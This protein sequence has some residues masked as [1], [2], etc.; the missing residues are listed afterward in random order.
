MMTKKCLILILAIFMILGT[1]LP[2]FAQGGREADPEKEIE[3][4]WAAIW[5][6]MD[7]KAQPIAALV[8][9]FNV[10]NAG[11]I[12]VVI[13]PQPDYN[14]Y[15]TKVRTSLAAGIAPADI[16]TIRVNPTTEEF[17]KSKLVMDFTDKLIGEWKKQFDP[18]TLVQSTVDGKL[19]S[20]PYEIAILP[21]W[22]NMQ[23]LKKVGINEIPKTED[24]FWS[25]MNK[26]K[27]AG[28]YPSS[29]MTGDNNAWTSMIWFSHFAISL[30]GPDVWLKPFTDPIFV[31]AA[32]LTKRMIVE[33]STPDAIGL[34]AGDSGGHFLA[35]RTA[36]FTNGPWY[37]GREDLKA[38]P[39][40]NDIVV[41]GLPAFGQYSN[42]MVSRI[43]G[44]LMAAATKD[45]AR[46]QAIIKFLKF[47]TEPTNVKKIAE[48]SGAMFAIAND[49]KPATKLQ[50]GF[51]QLARDVSITAL[52]VATAI[53]AE[54]TLEFTQQLSN[55]ALGRID[56]QEFTRRVYAKII[57]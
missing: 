15:D 41:A 3:L 45:P 32:E 25:V 4:R 11:K 21:I 44:N 34:R 35:Q 38:T 47:M 9:E 57:D 29:Q 40:Y 5:V 54:A 1:M 36:V 55:L 20:I 14:A 49:A 52:D 10:S 37:G 48:H 17:Y 27:D 46:E 50:A 53:G 13:E 16:W 19:K 2:V 31:K 30:G 18:A 12:K 28:I 8:E 51:D 56:A 39:F 24:D 6:G 23:L 42:Y 26:L 22:Y 7:S 43:Q 33:Y